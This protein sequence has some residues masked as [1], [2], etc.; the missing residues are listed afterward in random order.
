MRVAL[1]SNVLI[2][3]L[4]RRSPEKREIARDILARGRDIDLVVIA[5]TLGEFVNVVRRRA[6]EYLD[7]ALAQAEAV[8]RVFPTAATT[9][10]H[11]LAG[12]RIAIR[13]R[14]QFW[15]SVILEVARSQG[16]EVLLTEDMQDG[17]TLA[18]VSLLDPFKARN[19][20]LIES[21]L[22]G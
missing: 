9:A 6:P 5:Q 16:V 19:L 12:G 17:A 18:G 2:Y 4:D 20:G 21:L 3:S 10:E 8:A 14:L 7:E 11:I 1:D 15:D 22:R 13:H